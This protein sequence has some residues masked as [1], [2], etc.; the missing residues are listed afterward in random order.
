MIGGNRDKPEDRSKQPRTLHKRFGAPKGI[1]EAE[2][3][4]AQIPQRSLSILGGCTFTETVQLRMNF[5]CR[6]PRALAARYHQ[7]FL[8]PEPVPQRCP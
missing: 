3:T 6:K 4:L 8:A 5:P 2:L 1:T 7:G